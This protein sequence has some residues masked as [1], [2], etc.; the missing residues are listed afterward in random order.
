M[1]V[2]PD[3]RREA[4]PGYTFDTTPAERDAIK[5]NLSFIGKHPAF[6]RDQQIRANEWWNDVVQTGNGLT[7]DAWTRR[8]YLDRMTV[9]GSGKTATAVFLAVWIFLGLVLDL[10]VLSFIVSV[11]AG[12]FAWSATR[13]A[14]RADIATGPIGRF[15]HR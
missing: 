8:T 10:G 13:K 9:H 15:T 12:V 11:A 2:S 1:T 5:A 4:R 14:R 3:E 7:A 6:T